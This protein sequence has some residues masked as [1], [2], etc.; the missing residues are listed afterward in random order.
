MVVIMIMAISAN[1]KKH[2]V[3]GNFVQT[4]VDQA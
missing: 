4:Q 3:S 2:Y 1:G